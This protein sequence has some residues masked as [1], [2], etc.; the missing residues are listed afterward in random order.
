MLLLLL[1]FPVKNLCT[2]GPY[3]DMLCV[4][5]WLAVG[6]VNQRVSMFPKL[7]CEADV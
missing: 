1:L 2:A 6:G 5:A 3:L 7:P 4:E